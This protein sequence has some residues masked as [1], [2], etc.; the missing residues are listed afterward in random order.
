[1]RSWQEA[2][3]LR[4]HHVSRK[5]ISNHLTAC[6]RHLQ[7]A[8]AGGI[9]ADWK[10]AIAYQ[11]MLAIA[12]AALAVCGYRARSENHHYRLV[13]SL[14]LT[15]HLEPDLV[16]TLDHFRKAR[17]LVLYDA[18]REITDSEANE[19]IEITSALKD[20]FIATLRDSHP[21]L[22]DSPLALE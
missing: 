7:A 3:W 2:G 5:E 18:S 16:A 9:D 10:L 14:A 4:S 12:A 8:C 6:E 13:Q 20:R 17:H 15:M 22:I 11:A 1:M 21:E 19:I